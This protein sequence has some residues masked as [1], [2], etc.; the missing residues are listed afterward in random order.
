MTFLGS[1]FVE[2]G[3]QAGEWLV[4]AVQGQAPAR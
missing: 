2:E 4:E 1:D 3:K